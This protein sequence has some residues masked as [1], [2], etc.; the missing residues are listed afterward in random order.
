[1]GSNRLVLPAEMKSCER[2]DGHTAVPS[3]FPRVIFPEGKYH[4][5]GPARGSLRTVMIG[6]Q[7]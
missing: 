4:L 1:M 3:V 2:V 5:R 7:R 6:E